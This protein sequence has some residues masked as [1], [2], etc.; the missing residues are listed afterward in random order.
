MKKILLLAA[1]SLLLL[2]DSA[3]PQLLNTDIVNM[4]R[5]TQRAI[6][7]N[8]LTKIKVKRD[9]VSKSRDTKAKQRSVFG[10]VL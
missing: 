8:S 9:E 5:V 4:Q 1:T 3:K 10:T 7:T 2:A 6:T